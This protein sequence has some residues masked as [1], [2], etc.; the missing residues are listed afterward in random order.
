M[1][2][3][4]RGLSVWFSFLL[5]S[6]VSAVV[7]LSL[8]TVRV[9]LRDYALVW[10]CLLLSLRAALS[11]RR[12]KTQST[13]TLKQLLCMFL[14]IYWFPKKTQPAGCVEGLYGKGSNCPSGRAQQDAASGGNEGRWTHG[15]EARWDEPPPSGFCWGFGGS[16]GL[17]GRGH[18]DNALL[19]CL[20]AEGW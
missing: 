13:I 16:R 10:S 3:K 8:L 12:A 1:R 15:W 20:K 17:W 9:S 19:V 18:L 4:G 11:P 7:F 2:L 14:T 6:A 5:E